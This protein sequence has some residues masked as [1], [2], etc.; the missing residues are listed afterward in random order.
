MQP[1]HLETRVSLYLGWMA[2]QNYSPLSIRE[3]RRILGYFTAWCRSSGFSDA[4]QIT[5][6]DIEGWQIHLHQHR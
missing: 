2:L 6:A 1:D 3:R 4:L 5:R